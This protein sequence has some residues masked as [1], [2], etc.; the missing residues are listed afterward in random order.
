M[1][2]IYLH[3]INYYTHNTEIEQE[4]LYF[5]IKKDTKLV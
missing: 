3:L 1:K 4:V 5:L 2:K